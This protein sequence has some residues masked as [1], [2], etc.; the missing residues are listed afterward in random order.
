[1][2]G[3]ATY[4]HGTAPVEQRRL[5][6]MN[7]L[8]NQRSLDAL[9]L[10]GGERIL[11]M[12]SGL[13]QFARLMAAAA[14]PA[15]RVVGIERSPRQL[16]A[17]RRL[18]RDPE[19]ERRVRLRLGAAERPPLR[20]DEIGR[21]DVAHARFLL[22]HVGDPLRIVRGM[23]RA[24]RPGGRIVLEDDDHDVLRLHP[25]PP[26]FRPL[27]DAYMRTF[28]R[29]GGDPFV[30]RRLVALLHR[31]GARPRRNGWVFFG[32]CA[33]DPLFRGIVDNVAVLLRGTRGPILD[34]GILDPAAFDA[35]LAALRRFGRR[36]DAAFWYAISWAEG[37]RPGGGP[38]RRR[39]GRAPRRGSAARLPGNRAGRRGG[40]NA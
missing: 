11:E 24:V 22:E 1:M 17:A 19:V 35:A 2:P 5:A 39:A 36:P 30:G 25:E 40:R 16:A 13:G 8:V 26:G 14:G 23:V 9:A 29:H 12:G 18:G 21:F 38:A 32:A 4:L 28:D 34:A 3:V 20:Q 31:A 10:R 15:G 6:L 33:G 37:I 7:A 27:W